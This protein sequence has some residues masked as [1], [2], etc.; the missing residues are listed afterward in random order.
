MRDRVRRIHFV[1]IG[2]V[3]M[4]GV[5][6]V[7][8]NLSFSVS[9]SD[10]VDSVALQRL[11]Q[12]GVDIFIGHHGDNIA[13]ADVVVVSTAVASDNVEVDAA[14]EAKIPVV[15]RAEM[16]GE[17]MRFR[18]GIAV[19]GTHGK[20]TTTAMISTVLGR[21][22][23]D[24]TFVVGGVVNS[25]DAN[26]RL[27]S[28][29]W[30]VAEADESDASFLH[31]QPQMAVVT[32]IDVDHLE[33]Y[34][35]DFEKLKLTFVEFLHNLPF[36]GVAV[37]CID[38][39]VVRELLPSI[40]KPVLTYGVSEDADYRADEISQS[41]T[42]MHFRVHWPRDD[43]SFACT[44]SAPGTHNVLNALAAIAVAD[45][46][47]VP[48]AA[49]AEGLANFQGTGRRFEIRGDVPLSSLRSGDGGQPV[50]GSVLLVDDYAHHP[51]EIAAT[52]AAAQG[53][54]PE[55]RIVVV[56][57]PHRYSRTRDL[58]DD[59]SRVL[60]AQDPLLI[61]EVYPAGEQPVTGADGRSI[62]RAI[63]ARGRVDPVFV[64]ELDQLTDA[65]GA[66]LQDNDVVLTLGAGDI[67]RASQLLAQ[68]TTQEKVA[69]GHR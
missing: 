68:G 38:D 45:E 37:L 13:G 1:G 34:A 49:I 12:L 60:E 32:N 61:T 6:E 4:S 51:N 17:L 67:G 14:N 3:G 46:L 65:L 35:G 66:I 53:A 43:M 56:F 8:A 57:Q 47:E 41:G 20:T 58:M 64:P 26:A 24:P 23:L 5:A 9:G 42:D 19:A 55:R 33:A 40:H 7:L 10:L 50:D 29:Q 31:L 30:M 18:K 16:L 15:P 25:F 52:L 48:R 62:C 22:G 2:G 11:R 36:Y 54:W 44:L 69:G 27:G 39:P 28:G 21:A 63:R 59:F